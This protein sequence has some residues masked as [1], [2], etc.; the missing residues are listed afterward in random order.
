MLGRPVDHVCDV[1]DEAF[2]DSLPSLHRR[3]ELGDSEGPQKEVSPL[4][5]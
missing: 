1:A 2:H 3:T 4:V 5:A